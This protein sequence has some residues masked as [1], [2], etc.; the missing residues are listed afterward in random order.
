MIVDTKN[1]AFVKFAIA[2]GF[3]VIAYSSTVLGLE[4]RFIVNGDTTATE[5][6]QGD[7]VV[8]DITL[9]E[10]G[11][12]VI[13]YLVFDV[14]SSRSFTSDDKVIVSRSISDGA[15]CIVPNIPNISPAFDGKIQLYFNPFYVNTG[16]F[17]VVCM[18]G[19]TV[20]A[21]PS[22]M[23]RPSDDPPHVISGTVS[24]E[25]VS[26]PDER[27]EG[28]YVWGPIARFVSPFAMGDIT[29]EYGR[30]NINCPASDTNFAIVPYTEIP[31]YTTPDYQWV[32]VSG[33]GETTH[34]TFEYSE[35]EAIVYGDIAMESGSPL[36]FPAFL[37]LKNRDG[38][39]VERFFTFEE[40]RYS[41]G[42][43]PGRYQLQLVAESLPHGY[44]S[45]PKYR[46]NID[47]GDS[48]RFDLIVK[49]GSETISG[50]VTE[51]GGAPST[52]YQI[53]AES[54]D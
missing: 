19:T 28:I 15:H 17:M 14:D 49:T 32:D 2:I 43:L 20:V 11:E 1:K 23:V 22:V 50:R 46:F 29:D 30:F 25:D 16:L 39:H 53:R 27:L 4:A 21:S 45:P 26:P 51:S 8:L 31:G 9:D 7:S 40:D 47:S 54:E 44:T 52:S 12:D 24:I 36:P 42:V 33:H 37:I 18:Q 41:F 6:M 10:I 3:V 35:A 5:A 38:F 13:C 48:L 34:V